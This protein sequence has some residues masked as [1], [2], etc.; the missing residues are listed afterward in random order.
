MP[1]DA[2]TTRNDQ[3]GIQCSTYGQKSYQVLLAITKVLFNP[4]F[5]FANLWKDTTFPSYWHLLACITAVLQTPIRS[6]TPCIKT[7]PREPVQL[8]NH[9]EGRENHLPCFARI[10]WL[11]FPFNNYYRKQSSPLGDDLAAHF[12][13]KA[14]WR[15]AAEQLWNPAGTAK[16][17]HSGV[18]FTPSGII[19][20]VYWHMQAHLNK[21]R[22]KNKVTVWS[23]WNSTGS[24][25][26]NYPLKSWMFGIRNNSQT[27]EL[28]LIL[29]ASSDILGTFFFFFYW[30]SCLLILSSEFKQ[31]RYI[32]QESTVLSI[33]PFALI[34]LTKSLPY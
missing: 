22:Q 34:S 9:R 30:I 23:P 25:F 13:E 33:P 14:V 7:L 28:L 29:S 3:V 11:I 21:H 5:L 6:S 26:K 8:Q 4:K 12:S 20:M 19:T 16:D 1:V 17:L 2:A 18:R 24:F 27:S 15:M 10:R 31:A 32:G